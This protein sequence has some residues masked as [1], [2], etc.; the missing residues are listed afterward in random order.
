MRKLNIV[1]IVLLSIIIC[2]LGSISIKL[3]SLYIEIRYKIEYQN[4][5]L[6]NILKEMEFFKRLIFKKD[7][8][9]SRREIIR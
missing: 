8:W 9:K 2:L 7:C 1:I 4:D 5:E 3:N 6:N